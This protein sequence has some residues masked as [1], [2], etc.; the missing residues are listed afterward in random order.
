[1]KIS[2]S[3][4]A[5]ASSPEAPLYDQARAAYEQG[6]LQE[7]YQLSLQATQA[8]P[9]HLEAWLLRSE[10]AAS[11]EETLIC[12]N[13]VN[14]LAPHHPLAWEKTY[15]ALRLLMDQNPFLAYLDETEHLYH[16]KNGAV[17]AISVPKQRARPETYALEKRPLAAAG[18]WLALS[19]FGLFLAGLGTLLFVP[20]TILAVLWANRNPLPRAEQVKS[21]ILAGLAAVIGLGGLFLSLLFWLHVRG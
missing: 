15:Q 3:S 4:P 17:L 2:P 16:V 19:I 18:R 20:L 5:F 7:A 11:P 8:V 12:L 6:R 1:M 13:Q 10:T 21:V 9:H 14:E